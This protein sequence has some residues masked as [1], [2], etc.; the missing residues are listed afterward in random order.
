MKKTFTYDFAN[1]KIL[2]T[3]AA[4]KRASYEGTPENK[5]LFEMLAKHPE[6][7]VAEKEVKKN[8]SKATYKNLTLEEMKDYISIQADAQHKLLVFE[9]VQRIAKKKGAYYPLTKQWFLKTYPEYTKSGAYE[10]ACRRAD[11]EAA[12]ALAELEISEGAAVTADSSIDR[13]A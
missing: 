9:A 5:E 12:A 8:S 10:E 3:K 11:E 1:M 6:F 13:A 4:L 7:T 2:G